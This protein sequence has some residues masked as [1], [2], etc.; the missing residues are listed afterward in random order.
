M[1]TLLFISTEHAQMG[2]R[3][4]LI[5]ETL[6]T[7][8]CENDFCLGRKV[9]PVGQRGTHAANFS[10]VQG[11]WEDCLSSLINQLHTYF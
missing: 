4:K 6:M 3:H 9:G 11:P 8:G 10:D 1:L 5:M 7:I 2:N